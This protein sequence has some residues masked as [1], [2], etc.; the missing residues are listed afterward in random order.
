[1]VDNIDY[2]KYNVYCSRN[3]F[4]GFIF[5]A[6]I[7][8]ILSVIF[9]MQADLFADMCS[10]KYCSN[11]PYFY[12]IFGWILFI[13]FG[14]FGFPVLIVKLLRPGKFFVIDESGFWSKTYGRIEWTNLE[15][16]SFE[17]ST[18]VLSFSLKNSDAVHNLSFDDNKVDI[19][20][21]CK[22]IEQYITN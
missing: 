9:I 14:I 22:I 13:I 16:V 20:E 7:F 10:A 11:D 5:I 19:E 3:R 17:K 1:M 15:S 12:W 2:S 6:L 18:N 4:V 8:V 21:I